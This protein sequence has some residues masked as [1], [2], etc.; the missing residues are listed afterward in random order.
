[1][2]RGLSSS[3]GAFLGENTRP[4]GAVACQGP[5]GTHGGGLAG[6]VAREGVE[7]LHVPQQL[8][9]H[10]LPPP[11]ACQGRAR[12][13]RPATRHPEAPAVGALGRR[14]SPSRAPDG[15]AAFQTRC[16]ALAAPLL[17]ETAPLLCPLRKYS[18]EWMVKAER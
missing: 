16:T 1:V 6:V 17:A 10:L 4:L 2:T 14:R 3:G 11:P 12:G 18:L 9:N 13:Q 5:G 15:R 8:L 7:P